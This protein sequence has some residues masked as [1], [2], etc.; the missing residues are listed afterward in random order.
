[1]TENFQQGRLVEKIQAAKDVVILRVSLPNIQQKKYTAGQFFMLALP[2]MHNKSGFLVKKAYSVATCCAKHYEDYI[3][4]CIRY[5]ENGE[6][7]P[8]LARLKVGD[9][10]LLDGPYGKF[11]ID[12][13][14]KQNLVLLAG[15]TGVAPM[16]G[17]IRQILNEQMKNPILLL[18]NTK[19]SKDLLYKTEL[20]EISNDV[21]NIN[22]VF[23]LTQDGK[24]S[25]KGSAEKGRITLAM[26]KK[27]CKD[28]DLNNK[29]FFICGPVEM[30][31]ELKQALLDA[32]VEKSL[33]KIDVW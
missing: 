25:G 26:I 5:Y 9:T 4:F 15:G 3:E 6:L 27:Y 12:P 17:F 24:E 33:I 18:Y 2:D 13:L 29:E 16:M 23:S 22:V 8:K 11:T 28:K 30:I 19:T 14:T 1:M 7:S 20:E 31:R 10:I 32:G 21:S